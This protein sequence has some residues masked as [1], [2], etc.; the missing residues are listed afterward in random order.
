MKITALG[1]RSAF[2]V[3]QYEDALPLAHVRDLI[4]RVLTTP[5][6]QG[7]SPDA[8]EAELQRAAPRL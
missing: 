2:A 7:A 4:Q 8:L 6:L 1:V 3:G 5:E